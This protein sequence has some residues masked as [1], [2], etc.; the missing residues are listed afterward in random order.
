[1]ATLGAELISH[2]S[3]ELPDEA[4]VRVKYHLNL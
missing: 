3:K 1:M 4:L 2:I